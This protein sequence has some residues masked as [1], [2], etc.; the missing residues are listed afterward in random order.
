LI[1]KIF[2][3]GEKVEMTPHMQKHFL[4]SW[5][6]LKVTYSLLFIAAGADKFLNLVTHWE[7]YLSP[8][9]LNILPMSASQ[10]LHLFGIV[11]ICIGI[12]TLTIMTRFGAYL[13]AISLSLVVIDLLTRMTDF[14]IIVRDIVI[15]VGALVLAQ[16]TELHE[17]LSR[18]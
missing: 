13:M 7:K 15:I 18:D 12:L 3:K 5:W 11:E 10:F 4:R 1:K 2:S 17:E 9:I 6:M 8:S 14:D 16:L